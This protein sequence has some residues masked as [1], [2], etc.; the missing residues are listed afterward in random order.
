MSDEAKEILSEN[1][2]RQQDNGTIE[3]KVDYNL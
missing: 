1:G 3:Y 2:F